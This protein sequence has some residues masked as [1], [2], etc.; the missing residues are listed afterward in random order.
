MTRLRRGS[1]QVKT[2]HK[3]PPGRELKTSQSAP[4][5]QHSEIVRTVTETSQIHPQSKTGWF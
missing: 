4:R 1:W 3:R 5:R 2:S